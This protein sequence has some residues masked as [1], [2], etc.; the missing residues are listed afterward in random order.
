MIFISRDLLKMTGNEHDI[1]VEVV[2]VFVEVFNRLLPEYQEIML[3][4]LA[5]ELEKINN[6]RKESDNEI[7]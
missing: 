6:E 5:R 7:N 4:V 1:V 3:K 2:T